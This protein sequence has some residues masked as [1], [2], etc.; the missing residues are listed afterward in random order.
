M[1]ILIIDNYDSFTYNLVQYVGDLGFIS[2]VV[3]NDFFTIEQ[4]KKLS[5]SHIIISPGPGLP[6]T[7]GIS[8]PV[9]KY[10]AK[11]IPILGVCLGHQ[12]I[13]LIY[14]AHIVHSPLPIHGKISL[15]YHNNEGLFF[16]MAKPFFATR[17]HS[18]IIS[19]YN[20]PEQLKITAWTDDG[21]IMACEHKTYPL[22]KGI[23]FHPESLWT[24]QGKKI[25]QNFLY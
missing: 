12:S 23:Q 20:L 10:F 4:V 3:R 21:L 17:Y 6:Y 16:N 9:I 24:T 13:G 14:G 1:V 8:L 15:I 18:L 25:L 5:P 19:Q 2:K 22:L 11:N 7:A